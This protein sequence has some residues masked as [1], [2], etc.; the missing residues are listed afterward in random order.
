MV[1]VSGLFHTQTW[2]RGFRGAVDVSEI[3]EVYLELLKKGVEFPSTE[4]NKG[5][6]KVSIA[7]A[8]ASETGCARFKISHV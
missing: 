3:K 8:A 6:E 2:A 4:I 1:L 7:S 5:T